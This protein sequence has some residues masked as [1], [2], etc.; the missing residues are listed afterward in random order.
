MGN[1][2]LEKKAA[3]KFGQEPAVRDVSRAS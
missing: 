2:V 1:F 3:P